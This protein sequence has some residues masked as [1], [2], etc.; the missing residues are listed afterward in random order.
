MKLWNFLAIMLGMMIFLY[1][2]GFPLTGSQDILDDTG[3]SIN[4]T[5][6][7][8][9]TV[10]VS[11]SNWASELFDVTDGILFTIILGGTIIIGLF[12]KTL[13]WKIVLLPFI[14]TFVAKFVRV[15]LGLV[16]LVQT[17]AES[18]SGWLVAI[19]V[20]VFGTLAVMAVFSIVEW[21]GGS[22]N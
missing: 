16:N 14:T 13:D 22:D 6:M 11:N 5:N 12:G 18:G 1:F 21:F 2:L 20:T 8:E 19:I 7:S 9:S 17:S 3:I 4:S 15:G 10:D